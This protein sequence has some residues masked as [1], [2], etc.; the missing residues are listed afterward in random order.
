[1]RRS[2]IITTFIV[3]ISSAWAMDMFH[4]SFN[5]YEYFYNGEFGSIAISDLCLESFP[6]QHE[7]MIDGKSFGF[8]DAQRISEYISAR[9][10]SIPHFEKYHFN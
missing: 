6:C 8:W 3:L 9:N 4:P 1:M 5:N 7:V 2:L 10:I